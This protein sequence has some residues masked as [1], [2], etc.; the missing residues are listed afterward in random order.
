MPRASVAD[1]KKVFGGGAVDLFL[2]KSV[3]KTESDEDLG[4]RN[5]TAEALHNYTL[6][7]PASSRVAFAVHQ[8]LIALT[9]ASV[10]MVCL[11]TLPEDEKPSKLSFDAVELVCTVAFTC[12]IVLRSAVGIGRQ[13]AAG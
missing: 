13:W 4:I 1:P 11:D 6:V 9:V 5:T 10:T 12:E 3:V 7:H 8:A 2:Q